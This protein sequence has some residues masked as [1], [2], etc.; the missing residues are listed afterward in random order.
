MR[1]P[2]ITTAMVGLVS[3]LDAS[4][5]SR[6]SAQ[7]KETWSV[8]ADGLASESMLSIETDEHATHTSGASRKSDMNHADI[9]CSAE[10]EGH[11]CPCHFVGKDP[12]K[13]TCNDPMNIPLVDE[14]AGRCFCDCGENAPYERK[15]SVA[16]ADYGRTDYG[17]RGRTHGFNGVKM[18][19]S[20]KTRVSSHQ[21]RATW[22]VPDS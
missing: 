21:C 5:S 11:C 16:T 1:I 18:G 9:W 17:P 12:G 6:G 7:S 4:V 3:S 19:Y 22:F 2:L 20:H 10:N 15:F 14:I 8:E 13:C